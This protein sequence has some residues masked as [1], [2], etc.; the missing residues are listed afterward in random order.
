MPTQHNDMVAMGKDLFK[1]DNKL[2]VYISQFHEHSVEHSLRANMTS[3]ISH[4]R[5]FSPHNIVSHYG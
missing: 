1:S 5:W 2:I 3:S 4:F